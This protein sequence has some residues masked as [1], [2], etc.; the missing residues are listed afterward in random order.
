MI[1]Y[2][3]HL[4]CWKNGPRWDLNWYFLNG[5]ALGCRCCSIELMVICCRLQL[6]LISILC[7]VQGLEEGH[8]WGLFPLVITGYS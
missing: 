1:I 7:C 4:I 6:Y 2:S 3:E 5:C 8:L